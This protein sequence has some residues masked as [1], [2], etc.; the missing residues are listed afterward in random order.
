MPLPYPVEHHWS[1]QLSKNCLNTAKPLER[2]THQRND[3][4]YLLAYNSAVSESREP[5]L[6]YAMYYRLYHHS[7]FTGLEQGRQ[8]H[9]RHT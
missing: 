8:L 9:P 4:S 5:V 6:Q 2:F 7:W 3:F 1:N